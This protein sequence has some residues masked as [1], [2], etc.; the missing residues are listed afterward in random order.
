[1]A[2]ILGTVSSALAVAEVGLKVV[3]TMLEL[4]KL[5]EEVQEVPE[6]IRHLMTELQ[7]LEPLLEDIGSQDTQISHI[8]SETSTRLSSSYCQAALAELRILVDKLSQ[9][10]NSKKR[11]AKYVGR[12][13]VVLAKGD[14]TKAEARLSRAVALLQSSQMNYLM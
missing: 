11:R 6:T 1:M 12:V 13:K 8:Q 10:I 7:I 2:E 14:I 3:G 5:W 4:K 9:D